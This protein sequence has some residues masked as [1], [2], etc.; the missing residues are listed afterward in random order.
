MYLRSVY[1]QK[2][3]QKPGIDSL[4]YVCLMCVS[5]FHPIH[6]ITVALCALSLFGPFSNVIFGQEDRVSEWS[7]W[8]GGNRDFK[9]HGAGLA[10]RW[11]DGGPRMRW[12]RPLGDGHSSIV[13]DNMY[14][15][16]MYREPTGKP[17]VWAKEEIVVALDV[18]SGNTIWEY[19]FPVS[20]ETMN[21][22]YGAGPHATPLIVGQRLFAASSDKQFF[23]LEKST[24]QLLWMHDFVNE[25]GAPPNQMR[26]AVM[27]GYAPSPVSYRN[28]VIATVGGENQSVMAFRQ[29]T[30]DVV[31]STGT[32]MDSIVPASPLIVRDDTG[33][34]LIVLSGDAVHGLNPDSGEFYWTFSFPTESGVNITTPLWDPEKRQ[35]FLTAA[36]D[37]GTRVLQLNHLGSGTEVQELWF[38]K[39]MR[40]HH[41]NVMHVNGQYVGSSGDIG[42]FILMG[43]DSQTGE[44]R[45]R[46]RSIAKANFLQ[47]SDRVIILDEDGTLALTE[48]SS[49]G[50]T[51]FSSAQVAS[52]PAWTVPALVGNSLYVRDQKNI[53]AFD[54]SEEGNLK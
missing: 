50:L 41:T 21:F 9:A 35:L 38:T 49:D 52:S 5:A 33:V 29:D 31:W 2:R 13:G 43:I 37:G 36:L 4:R 42:A 51:V 8:G 10:R 28:L 26:F 47:V 14:L 46:D 6:L 17:D 20:L 3:V 30:G 25:F 45:W 16:T 18:E 7:G 19:R 40:V 11:P 53:M 23:A 39:R 44:V 1:Q 15:Y 34:Q 22:S 54:L 48:F 32:F 24:G 27:P 12:R